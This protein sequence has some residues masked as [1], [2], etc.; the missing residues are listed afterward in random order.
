MLTERGG[1]LTSFQRGKKL[2]S[3]MMNVLPLSQ[4]EK[5]T[6][7]IVR[8]VL[9]L[10]TSSPHSNSLVH[11]GQGATVGMRCGEGHMC[12]A[13]HVACAAREQLVW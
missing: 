3:L 9:L 7:E 13:R 2:L 5:D 6:H 4:A 11:T 12:W 10:L 8:L 1:V